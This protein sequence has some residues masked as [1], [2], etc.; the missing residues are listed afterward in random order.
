[1]SKKTNRLLLCAL[2]LVMVSSFI[3]AGASFNGNQV[4]AAAND[5]AY[6]EL[7]SPTGNA[8]VVSANKELSSA[9]LK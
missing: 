6:V 3:G 1:M 2:A 4:I 9:L 7:Y 5:S 8:Q